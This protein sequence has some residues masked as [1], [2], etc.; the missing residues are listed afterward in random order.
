MSGAVIRGLRH[1]ALRVTNL[2]RSRAFYENL[3]GMRVVWQ[4]D[5]DHIYLSSGCDNLAL[6]QIP[7]AEL[8]EE[9]EPH[10]R[11]MDHF[12]FIVETPQ[13]VDRMFEWVERSGAKIVHCPKRHRDGSYSFYL[14]DPDE[15]T[16]QILYEPTISGLEFV[17]NG[18]QASAA[19]P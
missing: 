17:R 3:F 16:I 13:A 2:T 10:G 12:G 14:A 8:A 6:H 15:N 19:R 4:P 7:P 9:M 5:P 18:E 1:V 11:F